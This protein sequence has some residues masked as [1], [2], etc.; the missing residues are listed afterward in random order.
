MCMLKKNMP[1]ECIKHA[2]E[3]ISFQS[4]NP[5]A[6]HRLHLAYKQLNDLDR[7]KESLQKAI[8]FEP[9]NL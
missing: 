4:K 9:N 5:K 1:N 3:A 8:S 2:K 6:Y 7:A